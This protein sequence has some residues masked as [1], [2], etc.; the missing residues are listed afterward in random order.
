MNQSALKFFHFEEDPIGKKI[1]TFDGNNPDGSPDRNTLKSWTIIG[2]VEDFHFESLKQNIAPLALFLKKNNGTVIFRFEAAKSQD[3]ITTVEKTWIKLAPGQ[4][5]QYSFLD[6]D[7]GRCIVPNNDWA[8]R[9][10]F[11]PALQ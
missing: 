3:V 4:P 2:V 1:S 5:F 10:L 8:K 7:F 11:L 6:E 9:L